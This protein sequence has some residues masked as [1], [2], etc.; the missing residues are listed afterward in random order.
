M[1]DLVTSIWKPEALI[2]LKLSISLNFMEDVYENDESVKMTTPS[3]QITVSK[4]ISTEGSRNPWEMTVLRAGN[5]VDE[6]DT[7]YSKT[8]VS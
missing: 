4:Q 8:Q 5:F 3:T 1:F 6:P 2:S 7:S